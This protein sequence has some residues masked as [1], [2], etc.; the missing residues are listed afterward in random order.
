MKPIVFGSMLFALLASSAVFAENVVY[1][2]LADV[3]A[4]PEAKTKLDPAIKFYLQGQKTPSISQD[5]GEDVTNKKTNGF[6]KNNLTSCKWVALSALISL[7]GSAK[8]RGANAVTD[9]VSYFKSK[10]YSSDTM[11]ECHAGFLMSGVALKARYAK[12]EN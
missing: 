5:L 7:Q 11:I 3:L 8:D 1:I 9:I 4:M 6:N 10:P 12:V 2:P